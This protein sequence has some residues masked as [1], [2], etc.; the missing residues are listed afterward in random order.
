MA[1][2]K[3]GDSP[4]LVCGQIAFLQRELGSP[5]HSGFRK[6]RNTAGF[7][8]PSHCDSAVVRSRRLFAVI[9]WDYI[10]TSES[11]KWV[12]EKKIPA[13]RSQSRE[14]AIHP[15]KSLQT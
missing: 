14:N 4:K 8:S 12:A 13:S 15:R 1:K 9:N 2:L 11:K 10:K 5:R 3:T 7:L 6:L